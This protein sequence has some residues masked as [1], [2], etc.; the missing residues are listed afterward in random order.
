MLKLR[1]SG[2]GIQGE[3]LLDRCI[4]FERTIIKFHVGRG[5]GKCV[6]LY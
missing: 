1:Q 4:M 2:C 6:I 5:G 3:K